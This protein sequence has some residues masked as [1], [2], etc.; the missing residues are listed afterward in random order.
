M[1]TP[2]I[3]AGGSAQLSATM[4]AYYSTQPDSVTI[5]T[6]ASFNNPSSRSAEVSVHIVP[7]GGGA[8]AANQVITRL[9]VPAESEPVLAP[10]LVAQVMPAGYTLYMGA[11]IAGAVSPFIS[12]DVRQTG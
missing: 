5:I 12:G 8:S 1:G 6:A 9:R 11:N 3:I 4:Q 7:P 2:T 10:T